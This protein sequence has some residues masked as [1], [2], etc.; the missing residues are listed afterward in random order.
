MRPLA[1]Y[2]MQGRKQAF[3][4]ALLFAFI[5]FLGWIGSAIMGLV[6]LRRGALEGLLI[7]A[8]LI[9]AD[10]LYYSFGA[11]GMGYILYDSLGNNLPTFLAA[12][13]LR[14]TS[15]WNNLIEGIT[16]LGLLVVI[17]AHIVFPDLNAWWIEHLEKLFQYINQTTGA[18]VAHHTNEAIAQ[19]IAKYATGLQVTFSIISVLF[20]VIIARYLQA[21]LYNPG[22]LKKELLNIE[23]PKR[24]AILMLGISILPWLKLPIAS[25]LLPVA[26]LPFICSGVSLFHDFI[27]KRKNGWA[28][29]ITFYALLLL[30]LPYVCL[31]LIIV[32]LLDT[33]Y[34]LRAYLK[35]N[36]QT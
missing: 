29:L 35:N 2:A 19:G 4:L 13:Y 20:N 34:H 9:I 21:S 25:D 3:F 32:G 27:S 8:S 31:I 23:M 10:V 1:Q 15:S 6:T 7:L 18:E 36:R 28:W 33:F 14:Q 5:P 24:T 26:A 22:G 16:Y 11:I 12:L 30:A 17:L